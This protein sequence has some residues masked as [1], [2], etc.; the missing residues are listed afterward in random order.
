MNRGICPTVLRS[1][2]FSLVIAFFCAQAPPVE[3]QLFG[4][5]GI[6]GNKKQKAPI[7]KD[8]GV[9]IPVSGKVSTLKGQEIDFEIEA[10]S[11]TRS[12]SV[13][14]LVRDFPIA[15]K[16]V[17]IVSHP[18]NR[19]KAIV[20][21]WAD[22]SSAA[23]TDAFS[24]AVRY[25]GGRYSSAVRYDIDLGGG[26][27]SGGKIEVTGAAEFG[28]VPIGGE[29]IKEI[30]VKNR[31]A[32]Q[33]NRQIMLYSPWHVIEPARG[34]LSLGSGLS[35]KIKIAFRPTLMGKANYN[36]AISQ[37]K[38]GMCVLTGESIDPFSFSVEEAELILDPKTRRRSATVGIVNH[39]EKSI[40]LHV[41]ASTRLQKSAGK[42]ITLLPGDKNKLSV[43]LSENDVIP[44]EGAVELSLDNGYGK[45]VNFFAKAVPGE[46]RVEIP[47]SITSEIINFG[48]VP[49]GQA[50]ERK[51]TLKNIGGEAVTLDFELA[52]PFRL[53]RRPVDR[54]VPQ[55]E[56]AVTVGLFPARD[57][58]GAADTYFKIFANGKAVSVRLMGN[59]VEP[60]K[61]VPADNAGAGAMPK[62]QLPASTTV[63]RVSVPTP[64]IPSSLGTPKKD[65][66]P[67]AI[68]EPRPGA[69][70]LDDS[71]PGTILGVKKEN[72]ASE[73]IPLAERNLSAIEAETLRTPLGFVTGTYVKRNFSESVKSAED[74]EVVEDQGGPDRTTLGWTSPKNGD[75]YSYE[76]EVRA[77]MS[78]KGY[79]NPES[80][81]VPQ[82]G[83]TYERIG[84]LVKAKINQ[85]EP[86]KAYEFRVVTLDK[87]GRAAHPT[88]A[89]IARTS[90]PTD[91]TWLIGLAT[92]LLVGIAL[93]AVKI[94]RRRSIKPA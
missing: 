44:F 71:K 7:P 76:V 62:K 31:G 20:T 33:F 19:N 88:E 80:V 28:K 67:D 55:A 66:T 38:T 89:V 16:I 54:L 34:K 11:K 23:T 72:D 9:P 57:M 45:T 86:G 2:L 87:D 68:P 14:F 47:N 74:L 82:S 64:L 78:I 48:R 4:G 17:S 40:H 43:S 21:Y 77:M 1:V 22:P 53:V 92:L 27:A 79:S 75:D 70:R 69:L 91:W 13:E 3:A 26:T 29:V 25:R 6:F 61:G 81:W 39:G 84:R 49:A 30:F 37:G 41:L 73:Y 90:E 58:K 85:L 32:T 8:P 24:F 50:A 56:L 51:L 59:I 35:Q 65:Q 10:H 63:N 52:S 18:S 5:K 46:I 12:A 42:S 60:Q 83:V 15:G 94:I 36:M 93:M